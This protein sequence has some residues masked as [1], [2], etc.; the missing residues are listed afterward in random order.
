[1]DIYEVLYFYHPQID[2]SRWTYMSA[3]EALRQYLEYSKT[4]D[5]DIQKCIRDLANGYVEKESNLSH[6]G[7]AWVWGNAKIDGNAKI[8]GNAE[9]YGNAEIWGNAQVYD[10]AEVWS[11]AKIYGNAK[12]GRIIMKKF[13]LIPENTLNWFGRTL[14]RIK[15]CM[16]FT[17]TSGTKIH[18]GDIGGYV[19]HRVVVLLKNS[20]V[21]EYTDEN[22]RFV[23]MNSIISKEPEKYRAGY[24][25]FKKLNSALDFLDHDIINKFYAGIFENNA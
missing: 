3:G 6:D 2:A 8:Y 11:N 21:Q 4:S 14:F 15:A 25:K 9:V 17:T 23:I 20:Q 24:E 10:D 22:A 1:M 5:D 13:E 12:K 19:D 18:A 7:K 16:D